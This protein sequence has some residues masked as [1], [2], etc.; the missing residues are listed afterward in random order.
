MIAL[1]AG[2]LAW[3]IEISI[4]FII[5]G[6]LKHEERKVINKRKNK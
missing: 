6:I 5:M 3:G 4:A 2:L 1:Y